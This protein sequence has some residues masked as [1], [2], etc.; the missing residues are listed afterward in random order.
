MK[1]R[2]KTDL[3]TAGGG[4]AALNVCFYENFV[5]PVIWCWII[6]AAIMNLGPLHKCFPAHLCYIKRLCCLSDGYCALKPPAQWW[7][8]LTIMVLMHMPFYGLSHSIPIKPP[9]VVERSV[10]APPR[11]RAAADR[12]PRS[13]S[14]I[15]W[16]A[17]PSD[18]DGYFSWG[19]AMVTDTMQP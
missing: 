18:A 15:S 13:A 3:H 4:W 17:N 8:A 5:M 10:N 19:V 9:K 16:D 14:A 11:M 7:T 1:Y 2:S 6:W 12:W